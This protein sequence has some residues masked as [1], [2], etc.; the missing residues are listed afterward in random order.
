MVWTHKLFVQK[1]LR[2]WKKLRD[3]VAGFIARRMTGGHLTQWDRRS[4]GAPNQQLLLSDLHKME[5]KKAAGQAAFPYRDK[6]RAT[7][8][9]KIQFIFR[10]EHLSAFQ[11]T[12][13]IRDRT[14]PSIGLRSWFVFGRYRVRVSDRIRI[15]DRVFLFFLFLPENSWAV[16][17]SI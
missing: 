8:C 1:M 6:E 13:H 15:S 12:V 5:H 9:S 10:T 16:A 11:I 3:G 14:S 7:A 4:T 17:T 2:S